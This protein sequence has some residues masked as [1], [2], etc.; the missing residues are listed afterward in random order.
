MT[1]KGSNCNKAFGSLCLYVEVSLNKLL[2]VIRTSNGKNE[3]AFSLPSKEIIKH[4]N[5]PEYLKN[6]FVLPFVNCKER[7]TEKY[8]KRVEIICENVSLLAIA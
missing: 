6:E 4:S 8:P 7:K 5:E 1:K 3:S 2:I